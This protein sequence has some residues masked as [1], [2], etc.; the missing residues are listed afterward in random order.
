MPLTCLKLNTT[1]L[2]HGVALEV[3][4]RSLVRFKKLWRSCLMTPDEQSAAMMQKVVDPISLGETRAH[5]YLTRAV[6]SR[7][8]MEL[9]GEQSCKCLGL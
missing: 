1:D 4:R 3:H 7:T 6:S 2:S 9:V 8:E 5:F